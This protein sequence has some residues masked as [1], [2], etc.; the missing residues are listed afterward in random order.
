MGDFQRDG[1]RVRRPAGCAPLPC[2]A[3]FGKPQPRMGCPTHDRFDEAGASVGPGCVCA[4][5]YFDPFDFLFQQMIIADVDGSDDPVHPVPPPPDPVIPGECCETGGQYL[6]I[7]VAGQMLTM[8][9]RN[10][11]FTQIQDP[12]RNL[13]STF[14]CTTGTTAVVDTRGAGTCG[15]VAVIQPLMQPTAQFM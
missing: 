7:T 8:S 10:A 9:S 3:L 6:P 4:R 13:P 2:L 1:R 14:Q 12:C 5:P 11:S 15:R